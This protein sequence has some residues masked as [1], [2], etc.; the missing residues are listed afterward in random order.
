MK[1]KSNIIH[2]RDNVPDNDS[3]NESPL[4]ES[5][6]VIAQAPLTARQKLELLA[7]LEKDGRTLNEA[8]ISIVAEKLL[9]LGISEGDKLVLAIAAMI[10][11]NRE[12]FQGTLVDLR[13]ELE[14]ATNAVDLMTG[15]LHLGD[16]ATYAAAGW[17]CDKRQNDKI[18]QNYA[19]DMAQLGYRSAIT[20]AQRS[21]HLSLSRTIL[22]VVP[23]IPYRHKDVLKVLK[24][25]PGGD[26]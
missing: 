5:K 4:G 12:L 23:P 15:G 26:R 3:R 14:S 2:V 18:F 7:D 1:P 16:R 6:L 17:L 9:A 22:D 24:S 13:K 11:R 8:I 19:K 10:L 20:A 21:M 25:L